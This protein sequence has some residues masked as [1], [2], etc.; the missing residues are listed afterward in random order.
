MYESKISTNKTRA[1]T[2]RRKDLIP[3][4]TGVSGEFCI[5][6]G[7]KILKS[8]INIRVQDFDHCGIIAEI[9]DEIGLEV[10][11]YESNRI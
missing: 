3:D 11:I 4:F 1:K 8:L 5:L 7:C 9:C 10:A 6:K 2:R